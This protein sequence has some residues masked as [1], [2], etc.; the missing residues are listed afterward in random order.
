MMMRFCGWEVTTIDVVYVGNT[1]GAR[2]LASTK[3]KQKST[4]PR[5]ASPLF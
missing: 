4:Q 2:E 1:E 5:R 3:A